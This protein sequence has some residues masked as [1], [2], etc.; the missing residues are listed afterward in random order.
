MRSANFS[1]HLYLHTLGYV[2][3]SVLLASLCG[4]SEKVASLIYLGVDEAQENEIYS[5]VDLIDG[6]V[7]YTIIVSQGLSNLSLK[8]TR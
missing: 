1:A 7:V 5:V 3:R 2:A 8:M 4:G 6:F